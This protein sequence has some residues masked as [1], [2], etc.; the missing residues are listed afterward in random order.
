MWPLSDTSNTTACFQ[1]GKK[2]QTIMWTHS[3]ARITCSAVVATTK[4]LQ[5]EY[6][7]SQYTGH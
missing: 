1:Q 4:I 6:L 7:P 3:G 2:P 5:H